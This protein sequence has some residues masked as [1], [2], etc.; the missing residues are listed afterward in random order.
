MPPVPLL[1]IGVHVQVDEV[2]LDLDRLDQ[3]RIRPGQDVAGGL[4]AATAARRSAASAC[5]S[6]RRAD[7]ESGWDFTWPPART[8]P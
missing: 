5:S 6:S 4:G 7:G 8:Y 3:L 2:N 1:A